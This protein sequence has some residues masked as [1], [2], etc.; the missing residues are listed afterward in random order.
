MATAPFLLILYSTELSDYLAVNA[1][2]A[3]AVYG[4]CGSNTLLTNTLNRYHPLVFYTSFLLVTA[5]LAA[6]V[7]LLLPP[8]RLFRRSELATRVTPLG[9]YS[10]FVNL[11]AL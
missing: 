11:L 2:H 4:L 6:S 8:R 3:A 10:C 7:L 1:D 9:W 5:C